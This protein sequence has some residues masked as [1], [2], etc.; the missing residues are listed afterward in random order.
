MRVVLDTNVLVS[1]L[2]AK[3]GA[4]HRILDDW[5]EGRFTLITSLYLLEEFAHVLS[6]HRIA[7]RLRLRE[8]E[9]EA[10]L[11]ALLD[12]AEVTSGE[13]QLPGVTRD[14]KDDPVVACAVEGKADYIVSGDQDMLVLEE[15]E[16]IQVVTPRQ[17][18]EILGT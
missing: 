18:V 12:R 1:G 11:A 16:A 17:F 2:V 5:L 3:G 9:V 7:K 13:L 6:Y 8:D 10:L 4:P 14:R 15:Y